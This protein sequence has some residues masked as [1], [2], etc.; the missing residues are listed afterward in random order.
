[1]LALRVVASLVLAAALWLVLAYLAT[2]PLGALYGWGGHPSFPRAP[3]SVLWALG[4]GVIPAVSLAAS[5]WL[6]G[7]VARVLGASENVKGKP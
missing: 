6:T 5:W 4:A 1:M 7:R 2:A 3:A